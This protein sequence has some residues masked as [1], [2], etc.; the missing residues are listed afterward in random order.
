MA[1]PAVDNLMIDQGQ[2]RVEL[3][4][5]LVGAVFHVTSERALPGILRNGRVISNRDGRFNATALYSENSYGRKRGYVCLFDLR[6]VT[7]PKLDRALEDLYFLDPWSSGRTNP[8][9]L[10]LRE[11]AYKELIPGQ[12]A[13][14]SGDQWIWHVECW[15]PQDL[16]LAEIDGMLAVEVSRR[17]EH[18]FIQAHRTRS[19]RQAEHL[20][21]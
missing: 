13:R 4:P 1:E 18:P 10:I 16:P 20:D 14:G 19:Q 7:A 15:Y 8:V 17:P 2:L 9:F 11:A 12:A 21:T 3:L 6:D 5:R